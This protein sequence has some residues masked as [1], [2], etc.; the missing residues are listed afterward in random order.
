V[1]TSRRTKTR[2]SATIT[3]ERNAVPKC[4]RSRLLQQAG[5]ENILAC[6]RIVDPEIG[7]I[8]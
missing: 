3:S 2:R 4:R 6:M 5:R 8:G 7:R 1:K